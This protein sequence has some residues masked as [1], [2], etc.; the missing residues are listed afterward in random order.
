[1]VFSPG[2]K[3][4][5]FFVLFAMDYCIILTSPIDNNYV[6]QLSLLKVRVFSNVHF[7]SYLTNHDIK[8]DEIDAT[9]PSNKPL[10]DALLQVACIYFEFL[11]LYT[12]DNGG[13]STYPI[14][15]IMRNN[16]NIQFVG[17]WDKIQRIFDNGTVPKESMKKTPQYY[18]FERYFRNM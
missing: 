7:Q 10:R 5:F 16:R 17:N 3:Y 4:K 12:V 9:I 14:L 11:N 2:G 13:H 18:T 8:F 6:N 1:M 15:F